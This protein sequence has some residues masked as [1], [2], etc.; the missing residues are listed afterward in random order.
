MIEKFHVPMCMHIASNKSTVRN[1][2]RL[3]LSPFLISTRRFLFLAEAFPNDFPNDYL[4]ACSIGLRSAPE[5]NELGSYVTVPC[6]SRKTHRST[7][8]D[9][10][11]F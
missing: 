11:N 10:L 9:W 8:E 4:A 1:I 6:P 7:T 2:T 5:K 3:S